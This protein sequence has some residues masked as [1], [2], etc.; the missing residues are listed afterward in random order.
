M[1]D[2]GRNNYK[3]WTFQIQISS[4]PLNHKRHNVLS[5]MTAVALAASN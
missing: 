1:K 2:T 5:N 4:K 3:N